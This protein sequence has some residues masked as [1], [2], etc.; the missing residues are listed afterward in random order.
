MVPSWQ[1]TA[2]A[3]PIGDEFDEPLGTKEKFWLV[4]DG[5]QWLFKFARERDGVTRG[6]DWA[7][8]VSHHL[9]ALISVP[10][11]TIVPATVAGRRGIMSRNVVERER[12][13]RLVHGNSLL[14]EFDSAYDP[15]RKR[16]N[17]RYTVRSVQRV[18]VGAGAP[19]TFDGPASMDAFDVWAGYLLFDAWVAGRDRHH[20]NWAVISERGQ[21]TLSPSYD[22]GNSLRFQESDAKRS[23]CVENLEQLERWMQRGRSHHFAGRPPLTTLAHEAIGLASP[24]ARSFWH[25]RLSAIDR[26]GIARIV[27]AVPHEL[28]S[29]VCATFT[30]KLLEANLRRL[31]RDYPSA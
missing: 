30:T 7:E 27:E 24:V 15:A 4:Q 21:R 3:N 10:C 20:E 17:S 6:E 18:L 23:S 25:D 8:W 19:I 14:A 12:S 9:A 2:V 29:D 13:Q 1:S 22:H 31:L 11:A 16:E 28:M 5:R 26:D